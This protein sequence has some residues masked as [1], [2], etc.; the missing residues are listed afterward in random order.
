MIQHIDDRLQQWALWLTRREDSGLGLPHQ[1]AF[2]RDAPPSNDARR[3]SYVPLNDF[4][5]ADTDR[6]V[7]AL[8][9]ELRK[10]IDESYRFGNSLNDKLRR[11]GCEKRTYYRRLD[12]AHLHIMGYLNDLSAGIAL[13]VRGQILPLDNG[14]TNLQNPATFEFVSL[15]A[16]KA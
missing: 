3:Q 9:P 12:A 5:C 14:V 11:C 4:E 10:V 7:C 15:K 13:P 1:A 8:R 6:A 16:A 2:M